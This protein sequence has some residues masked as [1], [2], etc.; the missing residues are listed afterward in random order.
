MEDRREREREGLLE[1]KTKEENEGR[2]RS[3]CKNTER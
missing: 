1:A 2:E 3:K